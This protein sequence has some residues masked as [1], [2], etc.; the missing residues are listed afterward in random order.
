DAKQIGYLQLADHPGRHEPGT[1]EVHYNRVLKQAH[2]L[3]YRGFVGQ[4]FLAAW[5]ARMPAPRAFVDG[6]AAICDSGE[7]FRLA[8]F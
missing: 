7:K 4:P 8:V 6:L 5:Q 1:G 3:G 2:D